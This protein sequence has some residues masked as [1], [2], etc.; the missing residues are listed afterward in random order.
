MMKSFHDE[1]GRAWVA[2]VREEATPRHHG[3][4]YL[5]FHPADDESRVLPMP[6][7]R[8][9]TP[10][11]AAR[12]LATMSEFELRRRVHL[13]LERDLAEEGAS[14]ETGAQPGI[15]RSRTSVNAG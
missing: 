4:W 1:H 5:V 13:L 12:T 3:R 9:Q 14:P 10:A 6:E 15:A 7:V 11:S 2:G 8:W